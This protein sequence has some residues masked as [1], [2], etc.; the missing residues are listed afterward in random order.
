VPAGW[1]DRHV[2]PAIRRAARPRRSTA[3]DVHALWDADFAGRI[4]SLDTVAE[5]TRLHSDV[6]EFAPST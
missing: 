6:P 3:A 5:M 2:V 1:H 4:V